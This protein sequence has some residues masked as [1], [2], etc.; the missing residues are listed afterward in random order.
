[1]HVFKKGSS[2]LFG[3]IGLGRFG[4]ALAQTLAEAGKEVMVVDCNEEKIRVA[5]A[6][7]DHAFTVPVLSREL[8]HEVGVQNCDTVIVCIGEKIDTSIL[9]TLHVIGLGVKRVIAKA[10]SFDQGK[11]LEKLGAEVVYPERDMAVR[12]ANRLTGSKV[13]EYITLSNEVDITELRLSGKIEG[14][15][16]LDLDLRKN[17]ALNIIAV[18]HSG[19][20]NTEIEPRLVLHEDDLMV[21]VGKRVNIKKFEQYLGQ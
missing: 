19:E 20:I 12:V 10:I 14:A 11:V 16:V 15:T 21:V 2:E 5:S 4:F 1:M 18:K 3:I 17:F 7:T 13:L 6:F 8:L 9:T